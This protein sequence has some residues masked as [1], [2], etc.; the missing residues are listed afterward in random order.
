MATI[1]TAGNK[2]LTYKE[3]VAI[4]KQAKKERALRYSEWVRL[5]AQQAAIAE[6][7]QDVDFSE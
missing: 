7:V 6:D 2:Q 3:K 1:N 4:K 5:A